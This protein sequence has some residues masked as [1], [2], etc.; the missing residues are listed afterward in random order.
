MKNIPNIP[1]KPLSLPNH[2][3][4]AEPLSHEIIPLS[5][6]ISRSEEEV[7]QSRE[8]FCSEEGPQSRELSTEYGQ[9]K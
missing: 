4:K 6:E 8:L 2:I 9:T 7:P 1:R 3:I 5:R